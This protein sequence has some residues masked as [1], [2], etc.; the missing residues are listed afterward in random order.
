MRTTVEIDDELR[1]K[2]IALAAARGEK[3]FSHILNEAVR[4][5]VEGIESEDREERRR[6]MAALYGSISE[7]AAE[8]M[9]ATVR[10]LR[11]N[12]R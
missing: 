12:W 11:E 2:L 6:R 5:Y 4:N 9:H 7:E 10:E 3:G 1:A 8:R